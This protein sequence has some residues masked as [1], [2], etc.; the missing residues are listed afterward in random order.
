M[1]LLPQYIIKRQFKNHVYLVTKPPEQRDIIIKFL[2]GNNYEPYFYEQLENI[3]PSPTVKMFSY[4]SVTC[5]DAV[6]IT[7]GL[8]KIP[9]SKTSTDTLILMELE[10]IKD[11]LYDVLKLQENRSG[12]RLYTLFD[13]SLRALEEIHLL[14]IAH[15]DVDLA[16]I[17][18]EK[19]SP[20]YESV[21]FIDFEYSCGKSSKGIVDCKTRGINQIKPSLGQEQLMD[22]WG[23]I[24]SIYDEIGSGD[25]EDL[26]DKDEVIN[27]ISN[28]TTPY[29][30]KYTKGVIET[31]KYVI[32]SRG[33][34]TAGFTRRFLKLYLKMEVMY[35]FIELLGEGGDG[36]VFKAQK[37]QNG[38]IIAVKLMETWLDYS[39][40]TYFEVYEIIKIISRPQ[41]SPFL[42]CVY[43]Y[44]LLN[45]NVVGVEMKYIKGTDLAK[46]SENLYKQELYE[47]LYRH[48]LLITKD[49][50]KGLEILHKNNILHNDI[51]PS[52]IIIDERLTPV[53]VD[54]GSACKIKGCNIGIGD[55]CCET[56]AG[57]L[58]YLAPEAIKDN[59]RYPSSDIWSL[60]VTLY[61][62]ATGGKMPFDLSNV[63]YVDDLVSI[64]ENN[65]LYDLITTN[66][67][68]NY[69][70]NRSLQKD[71]RDRITLEEIQ[72]LLKD[73]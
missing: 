28:Y 18:Y 64:I 24:T 25:I 41:C 32:N 39:D 73:Y 31:M 38:D 10:Y 48:L 9:R 23:L 49:I 17:V 21:L 69:I 6:K 20:S 50:A 67:L 27:S 36:L 46:Y 22:V 72:E 59:I 33:T 4:T 62:V 42:S 61:N 3:K 60:G 52:N 68:L 57:T 26:L 70:V 40:P 29:T 12:Q 30:D 8:Y 58:Y 53:L 66:S 11:T 34:K 7:Q 65:S 1:E 44:Y 47:R 37:K 5:D 16:N 43:D 35:N 15:N 2:D 19:V 13:K 55:M 51:K 63:L 56:K 71:P 45:D 54:Y 14:G